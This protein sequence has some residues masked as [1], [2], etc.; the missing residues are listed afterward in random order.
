MTPN[1]LST[2]RIYE[3]L[4]GRPEPGSLCELPLGVRDGFGERGSLDHRVLFFQSVHE[5]PLVGGFV[6]RL[7]P[8]VSS[9]YS[10]DPL[11]STFLR[12]SGDTTIQSISPPDAQRAGDLLRRHDIRFVML[13]RRTASAELAKYV[14]D[15]LPLLRLADDDERTLY[16]VK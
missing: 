12:L 16:I 15:A 9:F 4:R 1:A 6:A 8:S 14:Q 11:L 10:N 13:N 5:R 2:P 7:S 3:V